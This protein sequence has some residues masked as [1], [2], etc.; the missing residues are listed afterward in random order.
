MCHEWPLMGPPSSKS[1][2]IVRNM[3]QDDTWVIIQRNSSFHP[4]NTLNF[5]ESCHC[6]EKSHEFHSYWYRFWVIGKK[7]LQKIFFFRSYSR[8]L[9]NLSKIEIFCKKNRRIF[10]K[11]FYHLQAKNIPLDYS[12]TTQ[13][14]FRDNKQS[15]MQSKDCQSRKKDIFEHVR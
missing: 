14:A 15:N 12:E 6:Q 4:K 1:A 13:F 9:Q 2:D 5:E 8:V 10:L 3:L 11:K 7:W